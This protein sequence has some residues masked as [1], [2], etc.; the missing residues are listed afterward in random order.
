MKLAEKR[1]NCVEEPEICDNLLQR[2]DLLNFY[3]FDVSIS[4]NNT[5]TMLVKVRLFVKRDKPALNRTIKFLSL[6]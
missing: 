2:S 3:H 4:D 1:V 6:K 5:V